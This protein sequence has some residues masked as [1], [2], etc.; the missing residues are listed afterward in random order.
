MAR[1]GTPR[2]SNPEHKLQVAVRQYL[3][4]AL[5][6]TVEWTSSLAG[7]YLSPSQ[8]MK[9]K[10]GGLRHG[11]PDL[12]FILPDRTVRFLELKTDTG[13]LSDDQRRVLSRLH[14]DHWAVVRS[15]DEAATALTRWGVRLRA[16]PFHR[17]NAAPSDAEAA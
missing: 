1:T 5:P 8:R 13:R 17:V 6:P 14:P 10:A 4:V 3:L 11:F 2:R 9:A 15:V 16:H 7:A 12:M